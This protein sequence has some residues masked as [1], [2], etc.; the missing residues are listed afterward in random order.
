M[1][2][3]ANVTGSRLSGE[4]PLYVCVRMFP[5]SREDLPQLWV[6]SSHRLESQSE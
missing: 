6:E 2:N 4:K 1:V 5:D 3:L